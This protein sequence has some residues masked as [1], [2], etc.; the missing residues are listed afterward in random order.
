MGDLS[1]RRGGGKSRA[2]GVGKK[3]QNPDG[4]S[5]L[6]DFFSELVPVGRL[7]GE[8]SCMLEAEGL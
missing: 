5:R 1:A 3:V 8:E 2:A 4:P 6:S 7:F